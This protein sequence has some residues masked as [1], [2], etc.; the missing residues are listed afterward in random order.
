M[1]SLFAVAALGVLL[2]GPAAATVQAAQSQLSQASPKEDCSKIENAQARAAC[3]K[4]Q[5]R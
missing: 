5:G 3:M 4:R 2:A 1:K